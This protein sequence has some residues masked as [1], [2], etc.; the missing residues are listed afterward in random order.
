MWMMSCTGSVRGGF[1]GIWKSQLVGFLA[2]K[3][4]VDFRLL[5]EAR[6][7]ALWQVSHVFWGRWKSQNRKNVYLSPY[8]EKSLNSKVIKIFVPELRS[9]KCFSCFGIPM[10]YV[11][12]LWTFYVHFTYP[13]YGY[14]TTGPR[15]VPN[16]GGVVS[17]VWLRRSF[18]NWVSLL[19]SKNR[20]QKLINGSYLNK[21][22]HLCFCICICTVIIII[23]IMAMAIQQKV[24]RPPL[25][26]G[27]VAI[28]KG[29]L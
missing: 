2:R 27:V 4:K 20:S 23:I 12:M 14:G 6:P 24:L 11:Y 25:H 22:V 3:K 29:A 16:V 1:G 28:E 9:R 5:A 8:V 10:F 15:D 13:Y 21:S 17:I 7:V 19:V 18:K 26:F